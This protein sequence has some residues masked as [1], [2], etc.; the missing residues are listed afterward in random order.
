[1][2]GAR[3]IQSMT[4]IRAEIQ[5]PQASESPQ[6]N[7]RA[8]RRYALWLV[9]ALALSLLGL[10]NGVVYQPHLDQPHRFAILAIAF[11]VGLGAVVVWCGTLLGLRGL[12]LLHVE[13]FVAGERLALAT[14]LGLGGLSLLTLGLGAVHLFYGA[15]FAVVLVALPLLSQG[16]AR[17]SGALLREW[18]ALDQMKATLREWRGMP[19]WSLPRIADTLPRLPLIALC[20]LVVALMVLVDTI[21]PYYLGY[22][23]YQ[24]HWAV[25]VLLLRAHGWLGFAGWAH[26]NMPY[27]TEMLN[28]IAL[29][30]GAPQSATLIQ[31]TFLL[32]SAVL[33]FGV[34][35][36]CFG[37]TTAWLGVLAVISIPVLLVYSNLSYV[38]AALIFY[39]MAAMVILFS[40]LERVL[41]RTADDALAQ[42]QV[43]RRPELG[44]LVLAGLCLGLAVSVKYTALQ[45]LP[46][47]LVM[48]AAGLVLCAR[49]VWRTRGMGG[50]GR[51]LAVSA[52]PVAAF[53]AALAAPVVPWLLK[54]WVLLG[55][56]VYP[57]LAQLFP[58]PLWN[59][60]RTVMLTNTFA[61]FGSH[62]GLL[63]RL[64][65]YAVDMYLNPAP[66]GEGTVFSIGPLAAACL[67]VIP[68]AAYTLNSWRRA[69]RASANTS[70]QQRADQQVGGERLA[71][72]RE[73]P[74]HARAPL[75]IGVLTLWTLATLG[76]W[77]FSGALV[78]RYALPGIVLATLL[79]AVLIGWIAGRIRPD[80]FV[81]SWVLLA[82]VF[83]V[84]F[85]NIHYQLYRT[86]EV[87][88]PWAIIR[89]SVSEQSYFRQNAGVGLPQNFFDA[90][91]YINSSVPHDA[92]L[93]MLGR[94]SGYFFTNRDYVADTG[95]D[96][97]PYLVTQGKTPDGM[98]AILHQQHF[99]Y[100]AYDA[101]LIRFLIH[102]YGNRELA[103]ELPAYVSFQQQRLIFVG[104]WGGFLLY[105]VP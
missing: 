39:G 57:A 29:S 14:G 8:L 37:R 18:L 81:V 88:N 73:D 64:H 96:W 68:Y 2:A 43:R 5:L 51:T 35:R 83:A 101:D 78:E 12:R 48:V 98:L 7:R 42:P 74:R 79:G 38:E 4:T 28:L 80:F 91:D 41:D 103:R 26:A 13:G 67:L 84:A 58:T 32:L 40:W 86:Y 44:M 49:P 17:E 36:R 76:A 60:A 6:P 25:P 102:G 45:Y 19:G 15:T 1:M 9:V 59:A 53:C 33:L 105:R 71:G 104:Q 23:T 56:P 97:I 3:T 21:P 10:Y 85:I 90:V 11:S 77:T 20:L 94:G 100:V 93:L 75:L 89:G 72:E 30:L 22:D 70:V 47:A 92:R 65:L 62:S 31:D 69:R 99:G 61:N 55:D 82:A 27:A 95:G 46:A 54:D 50:L 34:V 16:E 63:A 24:Y 52:G 66:Y 87:R